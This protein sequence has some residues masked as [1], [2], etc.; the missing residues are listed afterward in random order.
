M[1]VDGGKCML[2]E[3]DRMLWGKCQRS[4]LH[5]VVVLDTSQIIVDFQTLVKKVNE[6]K[7]WRQMMSLNN[8]IKIFYS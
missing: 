3:D 5:M 2:V 8:K 7:N 1:N 4:L 6:R